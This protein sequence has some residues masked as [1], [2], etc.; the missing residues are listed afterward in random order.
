[1]LTSDLAGNAGPHYHKGYYRVTDNDLIEASIV[2][3]FSY[4]ELGLR[5][6]VTIHD[7][8]AYTSAISNAFAIAFRALGGAVSGRRSGEEGPD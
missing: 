2:A 8:D 5:T 6:M 1:M 4:Q 7:G 3:K